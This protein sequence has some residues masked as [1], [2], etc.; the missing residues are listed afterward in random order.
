MAD[1]NP[2]GL[3]GSSYLPQGRCLFHIDSDNKQKEFH[4]RLIEKI[5]R[6]LND[7]TIETIDL[8]H[9]VFP[10]AMLSGMVFTKSVIFRGAIFK[11]EA[12]FDGCRFKGKV[13]DFSNVVFNQG[14]T[15]FS[16]A[17][18][19]GNEV[20]FD[21][22]T[23][24]MSSTTFLKAKFEVDNISFQYATFRGDLTS[25][26]ST[27]FK[28][29]NEISFSNARIDSAI[30]F[31]D[32]TMVAKTISFTYALF[33]RWANF[34]NTTFR[35][36]NL[37]FGHCRFESEDVDFSNSNFYSSQ[38]N[39]FLTTF[40]CPVS[41][42]GSKITKCKQIVFDKTKFLQGMSFEQATFEANS[43]EFKSVHF[44]GP[45]ARFKH[46]KFLASNINNF[47]E[48]IFTS[49][50]STF[51][52]TQFDGKKTDFSRVRFEGAYVD[53]NPA[54]FNSLHT[55]FDNS[56]FVGHVS[57][58]GEVSAPGD[59]IKIF[60]NYVSMK[61][62]IVEDPEHF[63]VHHVNLSNVEFVGTDLGQFDFMDVRWYETQP[64]TAF[65]FE[66]EPESDY[67]MKQK[68]AVG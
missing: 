50:R 66:G 60:S 7:E 54:I 8:S 36:Q 43:I 4:D 13:T 5:K 2:C 22:A 59:P 1:G 12:D 19:E 63:L 24:S 65:G 44:E 61:N 40:N 27:E 28:V 11:M 9:Y 3:P 58:V 41:F 52:F 62:L 57:F 53:F 6:E 33:I 46:T 14:L 48:S 20:C 39:F 30:H 56:H 55:V 25:F 23:F 64:I 35:C 34:S 21:N 68:S 31:N 32:S 51:S 17:V 26:S 67:S 49:K 38:V 18:F 45:E 37:K 16:G 47:S 15:N 29:E 42:Y 10:Q